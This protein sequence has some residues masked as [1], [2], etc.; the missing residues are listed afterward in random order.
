LKP[1]AL[2]LTSNPKKKQTLEMGRNTL[3][4]I[5]KKHL[6]NGRRGLFFLSMPIGNYISDGVVISGK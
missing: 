3:L 1:A 2:N 6:Y 4:L 5:A